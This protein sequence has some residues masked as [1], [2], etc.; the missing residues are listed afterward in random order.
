MLAHDKKTSNGAATFI[1]L[2]GVGQHE[3]VKK[4]LDPT[5]KEEVRSALHAI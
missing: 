1:V 3:F 4:N 2:S 5:L